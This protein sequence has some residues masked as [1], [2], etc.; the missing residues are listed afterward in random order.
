[1]YGPVFVVLWS[2]YHVK[3]IKLKL[4][5]I[6]MIFIIYFHRFF[7]VNLRD[8][9]FISQE[10]VCASSH[11]KTGQYK[12]SSSFGCM[13]L[14]ETIIH[15]SHRSFKYWPIYKYSILWNHWKLWGQFLWIVGVLLIWRDVISWYSKI[16]KNKYW[17]IRRNPVPP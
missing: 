10:G 2:C 1:M 14:H 5:I 11:S 16:S 7:I 3:L 17:T 12:R 8:G 4:F 15:V 13:W 6:I 9:K